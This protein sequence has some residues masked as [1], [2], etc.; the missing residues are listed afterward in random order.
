M[1]IHPVIYD[2]DSV[3]TTK[4]SF[5]ALLL[6]RLT[7]SPRR[8]LCTVPAILAWAGARDPK[9]R[10]VLSDRI[11]SIALHGMD[12][13]EYARLARMLGTRIGGSASWIRAG[14]VE[15]IRRQY[16]NGA[17]IIIATASEERLARALLERAGVPFHHI[18]ASRL[19]ETS[20][21]MDVHDHRFGARKAAALVESGVPVG[22]AEFVTDSHA[23]LP[24]A[25]TAARVTLVHPSRSTRR[26]F[27][28]E[29][30][31]VTVWSAES[32]PR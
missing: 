27:D 20:T 12:E 2:L 16:S 22:T 1:R 10:A 14:I 32:Q 21:S 24:T 30:I 29:G 18:S 9:N 5:A 6:H 19:V 15:R 11:T 26:S 13:A 7:R 3:I 4:D 25:R 17:R 23:D 31:A 28:R 8:L